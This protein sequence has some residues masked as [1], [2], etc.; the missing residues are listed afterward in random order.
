MALN[1]PR[2]RSKWS[3]TLSPLEILTIGV[4][5]WRQDDFLERLATAGVDVVVDIRARR[6]VR[7]AEYAFANRTRLISDLERAGFRYLHMPELAPTPEIRTLQKRADAL[8]SID[9]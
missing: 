4:Y 1:S 6:G 7:G 8:E 2:A 9:K 3:A 5:G